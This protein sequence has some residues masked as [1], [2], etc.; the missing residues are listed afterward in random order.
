MYLLT[1]IYSCIHVLFIIYQSLQ[2][3]SWKL[4]YLKNRFYEVVLLMTFSILQQ[5]TDIRL[6][7]MLEVRVRD[8]SVMLLCRYQF[9]QAWI[10]FSNCYWSRVNGLNPGILLRCSKS[11]CTLLQRRFCWFGPPPHPSWNSNLQCSIKLSFKSSSFCDP[12]VSE[13]L[14]MFLGWDG[15]GGGWRR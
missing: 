5:R 1:L 4:M 7:E 9:K 11:I 15:G 3:G 2:S 12:S 10:V 8:K 13:F 14:K 6:K